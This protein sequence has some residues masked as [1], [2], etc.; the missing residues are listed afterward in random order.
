METSGP[1]QLPVAVKLCLAGTADGDAPSRVRYRSAINLRIDINEFCDERRTQ[2]VQ[3]FDRSA[4]AL[5][6][7]LVHP[8]FRSAHT[9]SVNIGVKSDACT[10]RHNLCLTT[11]QMDAQFGILLHKE[12][13]AVQLEKKH[14]IQTIKDC[15]RSWRKSDLRRRVNKNLADPFDSRQLTRR[16]KMR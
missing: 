5:I 14:K 8:F 15:P 3:S 4:G 13:C 16:Q 1:L 11:E 10:Q 2:T 9:A 6:E 12:T 7:A